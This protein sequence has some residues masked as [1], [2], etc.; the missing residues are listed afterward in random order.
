[1]TDVWD[2][3]KLSVCGYSTVTAGSLSSFDMARHFVLAVPKNWLRVR[4]EVVRPR[5]PFCILD[6]EPARKRRALD[7]SWLFNAV[8]AGT[9]S[10]NTDQIKDVIAGL[11][12][13]LKERRF[14]DISRIYSVIPPKLLTPELMLT[15]LRVTFP[16]RMKILSWH[17]LLTKVRFELESRGLPAK[18]ILIGLI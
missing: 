16:V 6:D 8:T 7:L 14:D 17:S 13:L 2:F 1:M 10:S 15:L 5:I 9:E 11:N 12:S 4:P 3:S 18:E